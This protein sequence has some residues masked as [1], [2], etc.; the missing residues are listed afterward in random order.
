[1]I[2]QVTHERLRHGQPD[3]SHHLSL[4]PLQRFL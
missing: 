3:G 2:A 1:L 4:P